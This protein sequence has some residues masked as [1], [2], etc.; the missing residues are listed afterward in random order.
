M[1]NVEAE[2]QR[3]YRLSERQ[4]YT[5]AIKICSR[6]IDEYP[7]DFRAY[8]RRSKIYGRL[9]DWPH[10]IKD[11]SKAIHLNPKNPAHY[12][13]RARYRMNMGD[14]DNAVADLDRLLATKNNDYYFESALFF[15]ALA[16]S[17]LKN[18][19]QVLSDCEEVRDDF[20]LYFLGK[21]QNKKDLV[22]FACQNITE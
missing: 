9:K 21:N 14:F 3:A 6:V 2:L 8:N 10:A 18:Y 12:F 1:D 15:R 16:H 7:F 19:K 13:S 20:E 5:A 17:H 11:V 22:A 4:L